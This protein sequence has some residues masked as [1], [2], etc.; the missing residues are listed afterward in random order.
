MQRFAVKNG[1]WNIP[2]ETFREQ[3]KL[4]TS[5]HLAEDRIWCCAS[6]SQRVEIALHTSPECHPVEA[7]PV[8][9]NPRQA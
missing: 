9:V 1:T 2:E 4:H 5:W 8:A 7:N 3:E 6:V